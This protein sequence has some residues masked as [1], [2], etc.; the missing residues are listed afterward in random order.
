M[1]FYEAKSNIF[2]GWLYP[3]VVAALVLVGSLTGLEVYTAFINVLLVSIALWISNTIKPFLFF[4]LTFAYQLPKEHLYPSDYYYTGDRPYFLIAAGVILVVSLVAFIVKNGI[5]HRVDNIVKIP[6]FIPLCV[7]SIGFLLN[8]I[9]KQ[10]YNFMNLVW[11]GVMMLVYFLL[12]I[13]IYLG[14]KG[15]DSKGMAEYFTYMTFLISWILIIQMCKIYFVDGVL[16]DGTIDRGSITMGYGV[17]NLIGFHISTLIPVNFYG[18]MKGKFP[19]LSIITAFALFFANIAT[20]SRNSTL[21]GTFYF[22]FCLIF[23]IFVVQKR[24][25]SKVILIVMLTL[26]GAF[27]AAIH[28]YWVR[29]DLVTSEVAVQILEPC[30]ALI[31][32]YVHRG[33]DS[34]GRTDIWKKC[35]EIFKENPIFGAGFFGVKVSPQMVPG[36]YIPEYAHNT[37]FELIAA[38]GIV[39]TACYLFYR[40]ATIKYLVHNFSLDRFMILLGASILVAESLLDNYAFQIYTTFYYI[41]AFAIAARLYETKKEPDSWLDMIA[42]EG[43][44]L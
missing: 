30:K 19:L 26:S 23:S 40:V 28:L 32:Q 42:K 34:S 37:I 20:T 16:K 44:Y 5:F 24:P 3:L 2:T 39:G 43:K 13:V 29:P 33:M 1:H 15:E 35:V 25:R 4:L 8:G 41:V 21:V 10:P 31:S 6:L 7:L 22:V 12:Y 14:I 18:F 9:N 11:A 38:T 27:A 36:E 17:C